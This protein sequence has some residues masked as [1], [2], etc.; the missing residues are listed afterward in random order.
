MINIKKLKKEYQD[1]SVQLSS[2]QVLRNREKY[3]QLAKRFSF[4]EKLLA[5]VERKEQYSQAKKHL[6]KIVSDPQ[7]EED[8]K[9]LAKEELGQIEENVKRLDEEI[10]DKIFEEGSGQ[11]DIII[12]IRAAAGGEES[13]LFS[14]DLFKMYSKYIEKKGWKQEVLSSNPTEI[15]GFKEIIFSVKG[16]G[17]FTHLKFES[18]V[19]RV[20]RVPVTESGGRIH[21]STV[22][23]AVLV[24]PKEIELKVNPEDLKI[25]TC[26]ASGAGG[27]HVN[28]TDSAVRIQHIPTGIVVACQDERSQIKNRAK[29]MR[30]LKA[31]LMEKMQREET[32]KITQARRGQVGTGDRSEKIRTYNFPERR[33]TDHR[34]NFTFHRLEAV[35]EGDIDELVKRLIK[36][37]RKKIYET[38]GLA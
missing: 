38:K 13:A 35:L 32:E 22:T 12:E 26:R 37:E 33:V 29:A 21:T 34:I 2:A 20:Q 16:H 30:V 5:L 15:G 4:L 25:E 36:E 7:E 14:T 11:R 18:G 19:H 8:V 1:L 9:S 10:E 6:A 31:R 28:V 27:Q 3:Q 24:E 17:A 23:V